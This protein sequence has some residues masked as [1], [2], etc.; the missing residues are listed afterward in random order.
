MSSL[1]DERLGVAEAK[2]RFSQL[3]DRVGR[4]ERI[5]LYRRG[6]P[7]A[8]LVP[9]AQAGTS[10][11]RRPIGLAAVAGAL[12]DW[13]A[14]EDVVEEIYTSRRRARDRAAPDLE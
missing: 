7:A 9:P 5:L 8:A 13:E 12:A 6:A 14:I 2:R 10:S 4:G 1:G 3:L 11:R